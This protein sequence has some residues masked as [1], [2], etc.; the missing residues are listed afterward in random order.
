MPWPAV[1]RWRAIKCTFALMS[2]QWEAFGA[3]ASKVLA[4]MARTFFI[5]RAAGYFGGSSREA[6]RCSSLVSQT[7]CAILRKRD[8][9]P[10]L[11]ECTCYTSR[12]RLRRIRDAQHESSFLT[13]AE[14]FFLLS[15]SL[16]TQGLRQSV[17]STRRPS[18]RSGHYSQ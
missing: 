16:T 17:V 5:S 11:C 13:S 9:W 14:I 8:S 2:A 12:L 15:T 18:R 6:R 3:I 7:H 1:S 10:H 4:S